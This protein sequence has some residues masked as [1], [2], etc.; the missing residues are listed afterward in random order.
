MCRA[1][2]APTPLPR[3]PLL[4]VSLI[5]IGEAFN[6]SVLFPFVV[7]MLRDFGHSERRIGALAGV[8]GAAFFAAQVVSSYHWGGLADRHGCKRALLSGT[9][10]TA[11]AGA[12]FGVAPNLACALA[13]RAL[14]GL[15]NGNI[16]VMKSYL[17]QATDDSNRAAA[18]A[19]LPLG[20]GLGLTVAPVIGG[21]LA[22]PAARWPRV[23]AA[24]FWRAHPYALPML[25]C[26]GFQCAVAAACALG[27]KNDTPARRGG[28]SGAR[29]ASVGA[30]AAADDAADGAAP[31]SDSAAAA[32][33]PVWRRRAPVLAC[34]GYALLAMGQILN[35]ELLPLFARGCLGWES[36][37]IGLFLAVGGVS[38]PVGAALAPRYLRLRGRRR[39]LAETTAI[40]APL[41]LALPALALALPAGARAARWAALSAVFCAT[42]IISVVGFT[43]VMVLVN[44][45][46]P[47][48]E[49]GK[50]NGLGQ[51]FAAAARA[52]GPV[53][54]GGL[55][56]AALGWERA[57]GGDRHAVCPAALALVPYA[58][59]AAVCVAAFVVGCQLPAWL[60]QGF[61]AKELPG[62]SGGDVELE[63][64]TGRR[65]ASEPPA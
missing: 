22:R 9:L 27:M 43:A 57:R 15:L 41:G 5:Q 53:C 33:E 44:S 61:D 31:A 56:S 63:D 29:Y 65:R 35:D 26:S 28:G 20:F 58:A 21:A 54:G 17:T 39:A 52:L 19:F 7:F 32:A 30:D 50:V 48:H 62:E 23:F 37:E 59:R 18:F 64:I 55:W 13:T 42:R 4:V 46:A 38:V 6:A 3:V 60:D 11:A 8:L 36:R 16:G 45:S 10:G 1:H 12:L 14:C 25:V 51:S 34:A 40:N 2:A 47:K 49:I 24:G